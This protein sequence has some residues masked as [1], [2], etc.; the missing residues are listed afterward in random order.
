M[1]R[2]TLEILDEAK[3]AILSYLKIATEMQDFRRARD[4]ASALVAIDNIQQRIAR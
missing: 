2:G 4:L 1:K 3:D